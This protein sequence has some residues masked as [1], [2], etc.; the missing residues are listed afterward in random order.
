MALIISYGDRTGNETRMWEESPVTYST[1][2]GF[3]SAVEHLAP[4]KCPQPSDTREGTAVQAA[5]NAPVSAAFLPNI[6]P[7]RML[8]SGV[9]NGHNTTESGEAYHEELSLPRNTDSDFGNFQKANS[10]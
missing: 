3:S 9:Q 8:P 1:T 7:G 2:E 4:S 5:L 6:L 10:K